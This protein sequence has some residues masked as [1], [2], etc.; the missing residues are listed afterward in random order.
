MPVKCMY[1][2]LRGFPAIA[3]AVPD[4]A[5]GHQPG[6]QHSGSSTAGSAPAVSHCLHQPVER[7]DEALPAEPAVVQL[8]QGL[9]QPI[10]A[11]VLLLKAGQDLQ[12]TA[13]CLES[14]Y[15]AWRYSVWRCVQRAAG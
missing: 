4:W 13:R 12:A 2:H 14:D 7:L 10:I 1:M 3:S 6:K 11:R 8:L 9:M 15:Q 5:A